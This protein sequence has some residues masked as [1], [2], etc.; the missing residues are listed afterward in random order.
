MRSYI[1]IR[2]EETP[3]AVWITLAR[4][5]ELNLVDDVLFDELRHAFLRATM[6]DERSVVVLRGTGRVFS[7]GGNLESMGTAAAARGFVLEEQVRMQ[8]HVLEE[9]P[10]YD[11]IVNCPKT[12]I[13]ALNGDAFGAGLDIALMCDLVIAVSDA[14]LVFAPARWGLC[15]SP[16]A[17]RLARR[18][19]LGRAKDLLF[20]SRPVRAAEAV[21]MGLVNRLCPRATF[22][23]AIADYVDAVLT[24]SPLARRLMKQVMHRELAPLI[25]TEHIEAALGRDF[26]LGMQAFAA[27][28]PP[29]WTPG[30][31]A[32]AAGLSPEAA[33]AG[34]I[35]SP[36]GL[37]GHRGPYTPLVW[38]L[39][40]FRTLDKRP[41]AVD[42]ESG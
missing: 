9:Y 15:D 18:I 31:V 1:R 7:G 4:P 8:E 33:R 36:S 13:A 16:N 10:I 26:S 41:D 11:A 24:T 5:D 6:D 28:R 12:T 29:P 25:P 34:R 23:E 30:E 32:R 40:E 21:E 38:R 20:T 42:K 2:Y 14:K 27:G 39:E 37:D 3:Q 19:G 17:T 35:P 22:D